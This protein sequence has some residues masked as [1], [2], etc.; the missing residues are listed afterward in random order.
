MGDGQEDQQRAEIFDALGHPTRIIIL[1]TLNEEPLGFADLKKR[2]GIDSSGHLQHHLNKL[3]GLIKTDEHGKYCLSDQ[4]KDALLSVQT[5]EKAASA[6]VTGVGRRTIWK[7]VRLLKLVSVLLSVVLVVVSAVAVFEYVQ[8]QS[9]PSSQLAGYNVAWTHELY[10]RI[11]SFTVADGKTF[12]STFD[13]DLYCFDQQ[14]GKTLW[15]QN[16]GGYVMSNQIIIEDGRV[17]ASSRGQTVNC[18]NEDDGRI[19]WGFAPNLTSSIT[20]KTAPVFSVSAGKVF[21]WGDG[22]YV[23]NAEDGQLL[24]EYPTGSVP[25]YIGNWVVADERVFAGG[26]DNGDKLFCFNTEDGSIIWEHG[27]SVNN[28]PIVGNG[29]IYVWNQDEGTVTC[30]DEFT[31]VSYWTYDAGTQIFQPVLDN[32]LLLFGDADGGFNA[33]TENGSLKWTLAGRH[34]TS[35]TP[36]PLVFNNTVIIG[37]EAGYATSINLSDGKLLW[38]TPV[39]GNVQ[40]LVVGNDELF[41]T[42]GE[43]D[44][45]VIDPSSGSI[46]GNQTFQYWTLPPVFADGRFYIAADGKVIAYE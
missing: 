39:S 19:L 33:L 29:R 12:T 13:G 4:G 41:V 7:N 3:D 45:Y 21:T 28:P 42:S 27:I 26:W 30:L 24:W 46:I 22:F 10:V 14:T 5:V 40:S 25:S 16:I 11:A 34:E 15:S 8:L 32:G 6:P 20:S 17:F 18:L 44:L 31:Q 38:R 23:L 43:F 9:K 35:T 37:L 1:K 36:A 2:V